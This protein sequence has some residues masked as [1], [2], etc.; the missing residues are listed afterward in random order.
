[1]HDEIKSIKMF[2]FLKIYSLK[3]SFIKI[4][5]FRIYFINYLIFNIILKTRYCK[6]IFKQSTNFISYFIY[7]NINE[8][9]NEFNDNNKFFYF[10]S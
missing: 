6:Q 1:M 4:I 9:V 2:K 10:F 7:T 3:V 5:N 8:C